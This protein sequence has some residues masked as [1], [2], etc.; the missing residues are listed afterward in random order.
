M[1]HYGTIKS[2]DAGKGQ[3]MITPEQGGDVL[4]FE[5]SD[6]KK[7]SSA[8]QQGQR[9]GYETKQVGGGQPQAINLR[10]EEQGEGQGAKH[11]DQAKQQQS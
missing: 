7:E 8:P 10:Q 4:K 1:T 5:K 3:G 6:L 2:Y 11:R 9:F